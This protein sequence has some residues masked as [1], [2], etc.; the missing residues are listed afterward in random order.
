LGTNSSISIVRLL[1]SAIASSS[2]RIDLDVFALADFVALDDVARLDFVTRI[3]INLTVLDAI[4][5]V[6]VKLMEADLL[7]L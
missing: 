1:S 3:R 5:S 4:A 7:S 2:F 6:L